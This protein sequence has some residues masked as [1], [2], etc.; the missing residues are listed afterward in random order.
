M[1][2]STVVR[3][4]DGHRNPEDRPAPPSDLVPTVGQSVE[5]Q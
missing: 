4:G 3:E 5:R 1:G 2:N